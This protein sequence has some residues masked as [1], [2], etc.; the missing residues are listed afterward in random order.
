[1]PTK[2]KHRTSR[3]IFIHA[4][5]CV[6]LI[7]CAFIFPEEIILLKDML[8][9]YTAKEEPQP[10]APVEMSQE[11]MLVYFDD[12]APVTHNE[13]SWYADSRLIR[14]AGGGIN[15]LNYSNSAEAVAASLEQGFRVIELD[16]LYTTDAH[17]VCAHSWK[18]LNAKNALSL[19]DF[20][21]GHIF[22]KYTPLTAEQIISYLQE[23]E[24][25]Y[26]V[27]DTKEEDLASVVRDLIKLC[28][29]NQDLIERFIVQLYNK[30]EKAQILAIYP[31][32]DENF[33]FTAYKFDPERVFEIMELCYEE[34]ISV[35]TVQHKAWNS[36]V[37]QKFTDKGF[38]I[39]EHTINCP[40]CVG[41]SLEK[42]VHGAYTDHL[43]EKDLK[44]ALS[45]SK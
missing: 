30:N 34:N 12:Y 6:T 5:V 45:N 44:R 17:L 37:I 25:L 11:D 18:D 38:I 10:T 22:G 14:H 42:G 33:L 23:F 15:G 31:F 43:Q 19:N 16:F 36:K 35:I 1:M 20:L 39:F 7:I 2:T 13:N 4:I 21:S 24:D 41:S 26:I 40:D 9:T 8:H 32:P 29:G 28:D 3:I 27:I